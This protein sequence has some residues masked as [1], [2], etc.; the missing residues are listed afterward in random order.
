MLEEAALEDAGSMF[1]V[2]IKVQRNKD[3]LHHLKLECKGMK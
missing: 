3:K 1:L 2:E